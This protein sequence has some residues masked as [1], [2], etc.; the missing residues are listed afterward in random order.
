MTPKYKHDCEECI[1]L[2]SYNDCDLYFC[3][4]SKSTPTII[5]R[6]GDDADYQSG[7]V[8]EDSCEELAVAAAIIRFRVKKGGTT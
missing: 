8:F 5:V 4:P 6:R 3:Q 7:F 2:G 1:F